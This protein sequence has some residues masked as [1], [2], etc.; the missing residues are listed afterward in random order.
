MIKG[1]KNRA[2]HY[3]LHWQQVPTL[4]KLWAPRRHYT[5]AASIENVNLRRLV[6]G[7]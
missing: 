7:G 3:D 4:K 2:V 5:S 6:G 1:V